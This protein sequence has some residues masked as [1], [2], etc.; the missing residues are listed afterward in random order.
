MFV[1]L[2]SGFGLMTGFWIA[3]E[4][5]LIIQTLS[6]NLLTPAFGLLVGGAG[7]AALTGAPLAGY[8]VDIS[9]PEK[10]VAMILCG[11]IMSCSA[12]AY[13]VASFV[14]RHSERRQQMYRQID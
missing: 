7:L 3:S 8:A 13:V 1:I 10:G 4:T 9:D 14:R 11:A 6:F 2:T 12:M 5:P